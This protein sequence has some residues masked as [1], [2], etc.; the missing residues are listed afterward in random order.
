L[1]NHAHAVDLASSTAP[2]EHERALLDEDNSY[3]SA[4]FNSLAEAASQS[5]SASSGHPLGLG[6]NF[7]Q[8]PSRSLPDNLPETVAGL[9]KQ[10]QQAQNNQIEKVNMS[11]DSDDSDDGLVVKRVSV[12]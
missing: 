7:G 11:N 8:D 10:Q 6:S 5:Q 2:D 3:P 9:W 1:I 12:R 4:A